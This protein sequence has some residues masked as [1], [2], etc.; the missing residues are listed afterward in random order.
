M[1]SSG[2]RG[3]DL[4]LSTS[5][6]V[7]V[8]TCCLKSA[9]SL[10]LSIFCYVFVMK[11]F[12]FIHHFSFYVPF[13]EESHC[14]RLI[15]KPSSLRVSFRLFSLFR[16]INCPDILFPS[17]CHNASCGLGEKTGTVIGQDSNNLKSTWQHSTHAR[18]HGCT[19]YPLYK[20]LMC[21][22]SGV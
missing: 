9:L 15:S 21:A 17:L 19:F 8:L 7:H 2:C 20:T 10:F 11:F 18:Q 12:L 22:A 14:M 3:N 16:V 4:L 1:A 5:D 13:L 6:R